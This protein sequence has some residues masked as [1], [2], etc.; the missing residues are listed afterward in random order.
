M[1]LRYNT[2]VRVT[3][4]ALIFVSAG[5]LATACGPSS[6][7]RPLGA[8]DA[9][10]AALR[11]RDFGKAY[12]LMSDKYKKEHTREDFIK[13]MKDS[14]EDVRKTAE[15]LAA[16]GRRVE[17]AARFIYDDL[18]DELSLVEEHG[19]WRLA[20]NPLDFYP[21]DTPARTLRSFVRA[22]ELKRWDV[23]LR[24]VPNKW[25]EVMTVDQ[26]KSQFDGSKREEVDTMLRLLS[27]NLD[28]PIEQQG[29]EARMQYGDK[30][31]VKFLREDGIWKV[32]DPD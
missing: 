25:K 3:L 5:V 10:S 17:V 15:R 24:F 27:A 18:G 30:F 23:V 32:E 31:E 4:I 14:P 21:Q 29:D 12:D 22:V 13:L 6:A 1:G 16:P 19:S 7:T 26:V 28:N 20:V 2:G 8:V 9:Y 11:S